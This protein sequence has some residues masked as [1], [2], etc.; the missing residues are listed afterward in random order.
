MAHAHKH[1]AQFTALNSNALLYQ[2]DKTK[3]NFLLV[4][5]V[6][7]IYEMSGDLHDVI[8]SRQGGKTTDDLPKNKNSMGVF[9]EYAFVGIWKWFTCRRH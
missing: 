6:K 5:F 3:N 8:G 9:Q 4:Y 1:S 2:N 7:F